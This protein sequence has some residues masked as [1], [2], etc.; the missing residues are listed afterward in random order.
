MEFKKLNS[1]TKYPSILTYHRLGE[2]G[3]LMEELAESQGFADAAAVY[4][5]EKVDGENA[6]MVFFRNDAG[7]VDYVIG[8][9]EELLYAKGDRIGNPYGFIAEFLKPLAERLCDTIATEGD[10]ALTVIYQ[11]SYGGKTKAAKNYTATKTQGYAVFDMFS[12]NKLE[13]EQL[14]AMPQEQIAEWREQGNQPFEAEEEKQATLKRLELEAAPLLGQ[15]PGN[16][17][18][19]TLHEAYALLE[20]YT[21]TRAGLDASGRAEGIIARTADRKLIRKL[22]IEDYERTFRK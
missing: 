5:Y 16:E 18:P 6:R 19:L 7:E 2:R 3:R 21:Q 1:L 11:E 20:S 15:L 14:M 13:W 17:F 22:R 8:S 12:L 4:L 9:R 10:W